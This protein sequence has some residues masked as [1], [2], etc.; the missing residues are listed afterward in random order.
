MRSVDS[1]ALD[2]A[3]LS[4]V[5][6]RAA[7][8][9]FYGFRLKSRPTH[10]ER[11]ALMRRAVK[12]APPRAALQLQLALMQALALL[13]AAGPAGKSDA[14][15]HRDTAADTA[16]RCCKRGRCVQSLAPSPP[17]RRRALLGSDDGWR[18]GDEAS[19]PRVVHQIARRVSSTRSWAGPGDRS[20]AECWSIALRP[21]RRCRA[22]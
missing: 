1:I 2:A 22:E 4:N 20:E 6:A 5:D 18:R 10:A 17:R 3:L 19:S 9:R 16:C 15:R 13:S 21:A 12:T 11:S 7:T 8:F 14:L